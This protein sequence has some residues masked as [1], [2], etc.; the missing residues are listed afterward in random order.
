M[1][2][3]RTGSFRALVLPK[4][5]APLIVKDGVATRMDSRPIRQQ[6]KTRALRSQGSGRFW[7]SQSEVCVHSRELVHLY[8]Y[9]YHG[10]RQSGSRELKIS[11]GGVLCTNEK[12]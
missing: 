6:I 1:W 9:T 7:Q 4:S 12:P 3:N 10:T 8:A 5:V 11:P 2:P